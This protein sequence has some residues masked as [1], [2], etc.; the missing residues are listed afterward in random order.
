VSELGERLWLDSGTLTPLLK[1][2]E[3][4]GRVKRH[5]DRED[6]RVVRI[7]LTA[8]GRALQERAKRVPQELMRCAGFTPSREGLEQIGALRTA[9]HEVTKRLSRSA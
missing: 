7:A 1:R 8:R 4:S 2:L 9:V 3:D 5:R 6:E